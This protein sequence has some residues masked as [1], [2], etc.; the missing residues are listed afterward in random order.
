MHQVCAKTVHDILTKDIWADEGV[1]KSVFSVRRYQ[2]MLGFSEGW[3]TEYIY[4]II[5]LA[6]KEPKPSNEEIKK[7]ENIMKK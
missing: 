1:R 6:K 7:A 4:N 5:I 3:M 2:K